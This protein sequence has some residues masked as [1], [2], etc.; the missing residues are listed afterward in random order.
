MNVLLT[1]EIEVM[2]IVKTNT[3]MSDGASL[4]S[5]SLLH[6]PFVAPVVITEYLYRVIS[7]EKGQD[8]LSQ[9]ER[10]KGTIACLSRL[11]YCDSGK[12]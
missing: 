2:L 6:S 11:N 7:Y 8:F 12:W 9:R 5:R 3:L 4:L 1:L 10:A